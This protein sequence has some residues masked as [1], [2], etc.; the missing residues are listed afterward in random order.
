MAH[1]TNCP[2]LD[3]IPNLAW[4]QTDF[5]STMHPV[6]NT[7]PT[8]GNIFNHAVT[9]WK[10]NLWMMIAAL[11]ITSFV[12]PFGFNIASAWVQGLVTAIAR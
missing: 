3:P 9:V 6:Q 10:A 5:H 4:L 1:Q 12:I 8:F 7:V 11:L 2:I